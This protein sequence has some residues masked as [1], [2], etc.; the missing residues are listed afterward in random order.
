MNSHA[1]PS[2]FPASAY[3]NFCCRLPCS[4]P[5]MGKLDLSIPGLQLPQLLPVSG[6]TA[7]GY[8]HIS[9]ALMLANPKGDIALHYLPV[10]GI[11]VSDAKTIRTTNNIS[12]ASDSPPNYSYARRFPICWFPRVRRRNGS[13]GRN[14][15]V[16]MASQNLP[17]LLQDD[18]R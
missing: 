12:G 18:Q 3:R 14:S 7:V 6:K 13:L 11:H 2:S 5:V 4:H 9:L 1:P 16:T 17:G 10:C 8:L 15:A